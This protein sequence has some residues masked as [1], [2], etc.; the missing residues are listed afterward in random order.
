MY[1]IV[2]SNHCSYSFLRN[3]GISL[4]LSGSGNQCQWNPVN[5]P[6]SPALK[7]DTTTQTVGLFFPSQRE[8]SRKQQDE[9]DKLNQDRMM[10]DRHPPLTAISPGR[11]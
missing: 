2:V 4:N 1:L 7:V 5:L 8:I 11:G 9:E 6:K 3:G 10:R